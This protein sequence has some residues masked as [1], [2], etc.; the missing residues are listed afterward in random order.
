MQLDR[1]LRGLLQ[2]AT[3]TDDQRRVNSLLHDSEGTLT[4]AKEGE[5]SVD[6]YT[7]DI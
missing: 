6:S 3:Q 5:T 1:Y 4:A 7:E 2:P